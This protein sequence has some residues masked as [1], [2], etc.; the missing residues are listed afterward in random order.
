[1]I[2]TTAKKPFRRDRLPDLDALSQLKSAVRLIGGKY[3]DPFHRARRLYI[4]ERAAALAS[5]REN[6]Y[7]IKT[8]ISSRFSVPY[9]SV[10]FCGS[11]QLGFSIHKDRLFAPTISDLDVAC[12][13]SQ[14]YN[15]AWADIAKTTRAFTDLTPFSGRP[16]DHIDKLKNDILRRAMIR[17]DLMPRSSLS[18]GWRDFVNTLSRKHAALFGRVSIAIYMSEYAFCWKQ[19]TVLSSLIR[20][21]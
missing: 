21:V 9:A 16:T 1:M 5:H 10:A 12:I 14:L 4:E 2:Y 3:N 17:V 18:Q 15:Q 8:D 7:Q 19:D 6:E 20:G 11:S 13:D